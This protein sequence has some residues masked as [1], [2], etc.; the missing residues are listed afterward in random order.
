MISNDAI[1]VQAK[2]GRKDGNAKSISTL[3]V[4]DYLCVMP[5]V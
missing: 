1:H 3:K 5:D 2:K 4:N